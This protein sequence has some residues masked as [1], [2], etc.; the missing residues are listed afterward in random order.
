MTIIKFP[1]APKLQPPPP[2]I[3]QVRT[4]SMSTGNKIFMGLMCTVWAIAAL[5]WPL[6]S[7]IAS[8]DCIFQFFR[9]LYYWDT[10]GA[11]AGITFL[12]HFMG[13]I[14]LTFF[15]FVYRPEWPSN[16]K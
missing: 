8:I 1:K 16:V 12:A 7:W 9:M 14:A 10:P 3:Q 5:A 6:I 2:Q 15:V 11:H 13:F 4:A